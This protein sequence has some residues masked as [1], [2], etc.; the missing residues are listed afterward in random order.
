MNTDGLTPEQIELDKEFDAITKGKTLDDVAVEKAESEIEEVV[1]E[2]PEVQVVDEPEPEAEVEVEAEAEVDPIKEA[3]EKALEDAIEGAEKPVVKEDEVAEK[4]EPTALEL[5][6]NEM[7]AA[8]EKSANE[9]QV[10][11]SM[12]ANELDYNNVDS[13]DAIYDLDNIPN[14]RVGVGEDESTLEDVFKEF[15]Q[16]MNAFNV[17]M[18]GALKNQT[19]HT[20]VGVN[21]QLSALN[22]RGQLEDQSAG[23]HKVVQSKGFQNWLVKQSDDVNNLARKGSISDLGLIVDQFKETK[24]PKVKKE[25]EILA[26]A[27]ENITV[28]IGAKAATT[29]KI[30][31]SVNAIQIADAIKDQFNYEVDRKKISVDGDSIKDVGVYKAKI[32]LHKEVSVEINFEVFAE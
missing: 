23:S 27:I 29:G 7:N 3:T 2:E 28:K 21:D 11:D 15:P 9:D 19:K 18:G 13:E 16:V 17:M 20:A 6:I 4:P 5:R 22:F 12:I 24:A 10:M 8:A 31:G 30:F 32:S 25:A 14:I 26:K 1:V